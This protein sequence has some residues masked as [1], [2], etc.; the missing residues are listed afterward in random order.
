[1]NLCS[2]YTWG[3][4]ERCHFGCVLSCKLA[5]MKL[6]VGVSFSRLPLLDV[7]TGTFVR[8][9]DELLNAIVMENG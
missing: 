8:S 5:M 7:A 4:L 3:K 9:L 2:A 1:M 6:I